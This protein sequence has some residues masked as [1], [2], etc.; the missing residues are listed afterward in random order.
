MARDGLNNYPEDLTYNAA[1]LSPFQALSSVSDGIPVTPAVDITK[2]YIAL[3]SGTY[4]TAWPLKFNRGYVQSYNFTLERSFGSWIAKTGYVG[5]HTVHQH[6]RFN[7]NYGQIGGGVAS[8][9]LY[10]R[11]GQ[12][13]EY[14]QILPL[15]SM[16]YNSLQSSIARRF[17][18]GFLVDAN[19]TWSKWMG[20]CCDTNG[21]GAPQIQIPQYLNLNIAPM[22]NDITHTFHFRAIAESPFG[23]GK[24]FLT[25]GIASVLAGGWQANV[26]FTAHTGLPFSIGAD[27]SSLNAPAALAGGSSQG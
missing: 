1:S 27:G 6:T 11:F 10:Q 15:E 20:L 21:D 9:A 14:D 25:S 26:V 12:T 13:S 4:G 23:K 19:Y 3:P 2:G 24:K 18:G 8:G 17:K 22:P 16:H 7:L 5:T